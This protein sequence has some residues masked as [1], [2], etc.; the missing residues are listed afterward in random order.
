MN[1]ALQIGLPIVILLAGFAAARAMS[2]MAATASPADVAP[3]P[4]AVQVLTMQSAVH[5]TVVQASGTMQPA[6]QIDL[7]T[8]VPGRVQAIAPGLTP[9]ARFKE[10]ELIARIDAR[11]YE[12]NVA[13]ARS[14]VA[15]AELNLAL[16][17][18]RAQQAGREQELLGQASDS[19][20]ARRDPQ[21][22]AARAALES[23]KASLSIA[24]L[25][26]ARTRLVAPFDAIVISESLD[27]G[28]YIAPGAPVARLI[29]TSR[30]RV[31][32]ALPV[33]ELALLDI[34]DLNAT[35]GSPAIVRQRLY[36]GSS[37]QVEGF[38]LRA[39]GEL[40]PQTRTGGV[41]IAIDDPLGQAGDRIPILPGAFVDV[42]IRGAYEQPT[43]KVPRVALDRG[44]NVWIADAEERLQRRAV[45]VAWGDATHVYVTEGLAE[46]DRVV[47]TPM[48]LPVEGLALIT[49][50]AVAPTE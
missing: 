43:M 19:P 4:L 40:D 34:P 29:G 32:V 35:E 22:T 36:D 12:A 47:V 6:A 24:E 16:E 39:L 46:G 37:L 44:E 1:R 11:D 14:A 45:K 31:R 28:Q 30:F 42:E 23:A 49:A 2:S 25:N 10:G 41:L 13:Q 27:V 50:E 20:L 33:H 8:Q 38:V 18:S 7:V 17:L 48:A 9:G 3:A 15:N 26:A 5:D 21:L